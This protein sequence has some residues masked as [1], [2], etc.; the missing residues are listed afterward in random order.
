[1]AADGRPAVRPPG[2]FYGHDW[3]ETVNGKN[4]GLVLK[5]LEDSLDDSSNDERDETDPVVPHGS[6]FVAWR[7]GKKKERVGVLVPEDNLRLRGRL[8]PMMSYVK[9]T[10]PAAAEQVRYFACQV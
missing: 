1:M 8:L 6:A 3:V 5:T 9:R 4:S 2:Q 7:R 10:E